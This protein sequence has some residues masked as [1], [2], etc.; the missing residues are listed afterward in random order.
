MRRLLIIGG[1]LVLASC[2]GSDTTTIETEDGTAEYEVDGDGGAEIRYTDDE[3]NEAVI[4]SGSDVDAEL[5]AGF[6]IYPGAEVVSNTVITGNDGEGS[7]VI[8]TS[9]ASV[10]DM[11][12]HYRGQAESA[13]IEIGM[14]MTAGESR[15][16][17]GEGPN[18][19]MF[20]F[21][22]SNSDGQTTGMLTIG[23]DTGE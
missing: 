16:I 4:T 7:L 9:N 18:G 14:E 19:E 17:G 1:A 23:R 11:V 8:M 5:P 12:T 21:N 22:A 2:G 10:E 13:G 6:T 3:G 15:I 20:S